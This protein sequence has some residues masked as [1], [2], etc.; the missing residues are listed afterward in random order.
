MNFFSQPFPFEF[1]FKKDLL[2]D[3]FIG[4]LIALF[5]IVFQPFG[6][7]QWHNP[8]KI[9]HFS[10]FGFI[11][12]FTS[13]TSTWLF[14]TQFKKLEDN[15]QVWKELVFIMSFVLLILFFCFLYTLVI[16]TNDFK[17]SSFLMFCLFGFF[18]ALVP[19]TG[20]IF[21]MYKTFQFR[22]NKEAELINLKLDQGTD[23]L[24]IEDESLQNSMLVFT[25]ENGKDTLSLRAD[26][27]LYIQSS[28]NY[29]EIKHL[30]QAQLRNTLIRSSL[31]RLEGQ[32][33]VP[34]LI[35]CHRSAIVNL[36]QVHHIQGNAQGYKISFLATSETI[37][38]SR[39]YAEAILSGLARLN[40]A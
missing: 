40:K 37:P 39:N 30:D 24:T 18:I 26:E 23:S 35:R 28:D 34:S 3:L 9:F 2:R 10:V 31:K 1:D 29:S 36:H 6:A 19:V 17:I 32:I 12:F 38:V 5:L 22:H 4:L 20:T 25:A 16:G 33:T 14:R 13:F 7:W 27:I 15:W 8:Y 11:S 21:Y